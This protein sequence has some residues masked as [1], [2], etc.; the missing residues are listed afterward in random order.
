MSY[1]PI[2]GGSAQPATLPGAWT[3]WVDASVSPYKPFGQLICSGF[4]CTSLLSGFGAGE[5]IIP[6]ATSP[7]LRPDLLAFYTWRLWVFYN[8]V[9]VWAGLPT[10]LTDVGGTAVTVSLTELPGYLTRK[11]YAT[12]HVYS[13]VEQ[14]TIA[15]DLAANLANIGVAVVTRA[16][17]GVKR[18][19][20]WG[21]L[22]DT[23]RGDLLVSL[24]QVNNGAQFR[25][26]YALDSG[27]TLPTCT[28][29]VAYPRVGVAGNASGLALIVPG[30]AASFQAVWSSDM[31]RT[32]TFA[33]GDVPNVNTPPFPASGHTV[34][35]GYSQAVQAVITG[36]TWG[37]SGNVSVN[38]ATAGTG[39]GTYS[40]P[41]GGSITLT[42]SGTGSNAPSWNWQAASQEQP[43]LTDFRPQ[44]NVPPLDSADDWPGVSWVPTLTERA[45]TNATIYAGPTLAL[46]AVMPIGDPP[47]GSYGVGDDVSVVLAD[48]LLP[49]GMATTGQLTQL[50]LDAAAGTATWTVSI[51]QPPPR[52][53]NRLAVRLAAADARFRGKFH[54]NLVSPPTGIET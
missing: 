53:T 50:D 42:Y 29:V 1:P 10:G 15:A 41:P 3:F 40:I 5:A 52:L 47:L 39:P 45:A 22:E 2:P 25:A 43:V 9:P 23:S 30:G 14:T 26:E 34:T 19:R 28:L 27:T 20:T 4:T 6:V 32:R 35:S 51:T 8:G 48:P 54:N 36:G 18:D 12:S 38:G 46:T 13:Q 16:G 7:M 21:Y 44:A 49:A 37:G 33:V 11:Q 31:M 17:T 24:M